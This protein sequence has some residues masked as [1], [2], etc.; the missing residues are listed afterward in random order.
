MSQG[1]A[2]Q[3][4]LYKGDRKMSGDLRHI[5][6]VMNQHSFAKPE[7]KEKIRKSDDTPLVHESCKCS[8]F[9]LI[10]GAIGLLVF[11]GIILY[12]LIV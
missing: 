4:I 9:S 5:N 8:N 3:N 10:A 6:N 7:R 1:K 12:A 11:A 2:N